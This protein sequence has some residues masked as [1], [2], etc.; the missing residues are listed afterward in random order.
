MLRSV[1]CFQGAQ[2]MLQNLP[3]E[4]VSP[5]HLAEVAQHGG[6]WQHICDSTPQIEALL[7]QFH[8]ALRAEM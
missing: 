7:E 5:E 4:C 3:Y 1:P 2:E 6:R 8:S